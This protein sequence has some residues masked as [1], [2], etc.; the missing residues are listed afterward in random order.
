MELNFKT[1]LGMGG[2]LPLLLF[3]VFIV[4]VIITFPGQMEKCKRYR[5]Y[6]DPISQLNL[7]FFGYF[8][9][10]FVNYLYYG[11]CRKFIIS[12][13]FAELH[14]VL[15]I[16]IVSTIAVILF[17]RSESVHKVRHFI[18]I[19]LFMEFVGILIVSLLHALGL[20][21]GNIVPV[22][23]L[24]ILL[25][26]VLQIVNIIKMDCNRGGCLHLLGNSYF[27]LSFVFYVIF[28]LLFAIALLFENN[29]F[30]MLLSSI[31]ILLYYTLSYLWLRCGERSFLSIRL[32]NMSDNYRQEVRLLTDD[33]AEYGS[34]EIK[35][36]LFLLF[37]TEKPYLSP[38]LTISDLAKM[39]CTNQSYLSKFLN[40]N[41]RMN[42]NEFVNKYRVDEAISLYEKDNSLN[43]ADLCRMSGFR[44]VSSFNNAFRL[45]TG[46]TPGDWCRRKK[47]VGGYEKIK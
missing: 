42:F 33:S 2:Y 20:T 30:Q 43:L 28:V 15:A 17:A 24:A 14:L 21:F 44:N 22:S 41:V 8:L 45:Y 1:F 12:S 9:S 18:F 3:F 27:L 29:L 46:C 40:N 6:K 34:T 7:I 37:E 31:L 4:F 36:R 38:N 32:Q 10:L 26:V 25:M 19:S 5:F 11:L 13:H 35:E 39:L 23:I 47:Y 16:P